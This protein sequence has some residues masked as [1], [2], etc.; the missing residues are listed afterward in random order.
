[1]ALARLTGRLQDMFG[2]GSIVRITACAGLA[3]SLSC[4]DKAP[5]AAWPEPPPPVL[6]NP[7]EATPRDAGPEANEPPPELDAAANE[8]E[9]GAVSI[10]AEPASAS[11]PESA[12]SGASESESPDVSKSPGRQSR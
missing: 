2:A 12:S 6:A 5:P 10:E 7:I 9:D 4:V 1:M 11:A 3:L 8:P